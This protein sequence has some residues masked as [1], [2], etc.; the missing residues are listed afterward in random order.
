MLLTFYV[1]SSQRLDYPLLLGLN[2]F[3]NLM[4]GDLDRGNNFN[5]TRGHNDARLRST[6]TAPNMVGKC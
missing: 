3:V 1:N 4:L 6:Q 2:K 5:L